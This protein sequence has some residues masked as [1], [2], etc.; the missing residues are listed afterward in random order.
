MSACIKTHLPCPACK[1][2]LNKE[3]TPRG[4]AWIWCGNIFCVSPVC[5]NGQEGPTEYEAFTILCVE[6]CQEKPRPK[7]EPE[8]SVEDEQELKETRLGEWRFE[9]DRA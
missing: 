6:Y 3:N 2:G 5:D 4:T 7:P 1:H 8:M 9:R